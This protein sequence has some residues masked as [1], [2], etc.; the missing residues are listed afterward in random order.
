M[1]GGTL[2]SHYTR[3]IITIS[4]IL[5]PPVVRTVIIVQDRNLACLIDWPQ[6]KLVLTDT[7]STR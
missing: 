7:F 4:F 2:L 6:G 5:H 3:Y 1:Y